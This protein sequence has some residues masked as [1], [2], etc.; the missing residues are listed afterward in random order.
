MIGQHPVVRSMG[1]FTRIARDNQ[2]MNVGG[3][4][5]RQAN[6]NGRKFPKVYPAQMANVMVVGI[7][8]SDDLNEN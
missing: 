1:M 2:T 7:V 6:C 8:S 4:M 3:V 5:P